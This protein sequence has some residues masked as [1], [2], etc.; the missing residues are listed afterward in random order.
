MNNE[1]RKVLNLISGKIETMKE[2]LESLRDLLDA[3]KDEEQEAFDNLPEGLQQADR[4]QAMEAAVEKLQEV[5]D[6]ADDAC[7]RLQEAVDAIAEA[8][9]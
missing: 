3:V 9:Q 6:A 4:G 2:E 5:Y 7:E 8:A 1:R